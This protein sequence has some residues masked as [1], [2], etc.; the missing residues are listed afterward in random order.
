V[1]GNPAPA[2]TWSNRG[3]TP[4]GRSYPSTLCPAAVRNDRRVVE[5]L[6]SASAR[7]RRRCRHD[8]VSPAVSWGVSAAPSS[9][10]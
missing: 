5:R 1:R 3:A 7:E 8:G 2:R 4:R 9:L 10:R 6:G